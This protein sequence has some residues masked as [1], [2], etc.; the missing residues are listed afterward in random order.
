M[1]WSVFDTHPFGVAILQEVH[2]LAFSLKRNDIHSFSFH[3]S[4][5][6]TNPYQLIQQQDNSLKNNNS[7]KENKKKNNVLYYIYKE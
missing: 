6:P 1:N 5:L 7:K 4:Y 2:H 3:L